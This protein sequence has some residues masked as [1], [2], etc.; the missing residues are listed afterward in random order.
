MT[1]A[2]DSVFTENIRTGTTDPHTWTHTPSGTLRGVYVI[3]AQIGL[4]DEVAGVTYG[5]ETMTRVTAVFTNTAEDVS[6]YAYFL[7]ENIPTGAQTVSVDFT[8]A[9]ATD[10]GMVSGGFTSDA[11]LD[12]EVIDFE[13]ATG[14]FA[15]PQLT[16]NHGGR[17]CADICMLSS[18]N[19][20]PSGTLVSGTTAIHSQDMG[21]W[22]MQCSRNTT[23]GTSD[24]TLGWTLIAEDVA[25][26]VFAA[27]E[28]VSVAPALIS[29]TAATFSPTI[30]P[31]SVSVTP[32]LI[33]QAA[34]TFSPSIAQVTS[35]IVGLINQAAATF[36]PTVTPGQVAV[37][38]GLV[39]QTAATFS[40]TITAGNSVSLELISQVAST[41]TPTVVPGSITVA[42]GLIS[43]L[44]AVF[45]VQLDQSDAPLGGG[46]FGWLMPWRKRRT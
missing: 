9:T 20:A 13:T 39:T 22:M 44:A 19:A 21:A 4:T 17:T 37:T 27:A 38:P 1:I 25:M 40:P 10:F 29:Q 7:G 15:D 34:A 12:I 8:S 23:P 30:N 16:M 28:V 43:Q 18:G 42:P 2:H 46:A 3:I 6:A 26:V 31:G 33:S 11:N 14:L 32:G 36:S 41:F 45:A 35:V 24:Q 5:G